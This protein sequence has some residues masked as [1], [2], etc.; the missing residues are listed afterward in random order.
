MATPARSLI[1]VVAAAALCSG[2]FRFAWER[3]T[4]QVPPS[5]EAL[6]DIVAG[7]TTLAHCLDRLG[8]PLYVWE[9]K[10][11]GLALAYGWLE[12]DN[13][14]VSAS[15]SVAHDMSASFSYDDSDAR[16]R[17][18]VLLFD[19]DLKLELSKSGYLRDLSLEFARRRPADTST[20][21]PPDAAEAENVP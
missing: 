11:N 2:C 7:E 12:V 1:G 9:Y 15:V 13:K 3:E 10:Q 4:R 21:E 19:Q 20:S 18:V 6:A 17:G 14:G 16:L 5:K 8:A